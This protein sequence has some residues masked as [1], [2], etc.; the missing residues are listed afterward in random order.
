MILNDLSFV[1]HN[2]MKMN[3]MKDIMI[4]TVLACV[5]RKMLGKEMLGHLGGVE[6]YYR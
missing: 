3:L 1:K 5:T 4:V 6:Q 2:T